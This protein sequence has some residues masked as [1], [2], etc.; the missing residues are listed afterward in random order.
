[1]FNGKRNSRDLASAAASDGENF[2]LLAKSNADEGGGGADFPAAATDRQL[3][4]IE[5]AG[6]IRNG[7]FI[8][9]CRDN[10]WPIEW[11]F[12]WQHPIIIIHPPDI[13]TVYIYWRLTKY[14]NGGQ[15]IN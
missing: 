8:D 4:S 5:M 1:M 14:I 2:A 15:P 13:D 9:G 7:E 12:L 10:N 11:W 3:D 6:S